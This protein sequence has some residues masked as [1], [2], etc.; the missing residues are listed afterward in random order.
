[1][2]TEFSHFKTV[3]NECVSY[4]RSLF[5]SLPEII[6][7]CA[8]PKMLILHFCDKSKCFSLLGLTFVLQVKP[9][10]KAIWSLHPCVNQNSLFVKQRERSVCPIKFIDE[11]E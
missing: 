7:I 2:L 11:E 4:H 8:S 3:I 1:M 6:I 10:P 5:G 9:I